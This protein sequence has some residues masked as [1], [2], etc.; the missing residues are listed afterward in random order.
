MIILSYKQY[1]KYIKQVMKAELYAF[2]CW[3]KNNKLYAFLMVVWP[4]LMA[5]FLLELGLMLGNLDVYKERMNVT[6]PILY[7]ILSS[8]ILVS[9][10][11]IVDQAVASVLMHRWIGTLPYVMTSLPGF[12]L[13]IIFGPLLPSILSSFIVI[14]AIMPAALLIEGVLGL[15]KI[16][17]ALAFIYLA[18]FPLLGFSIIIAGITLVLREETNIVSFITPFMMVLSGVYYPLAVLPLVLQ[19]LARVVPV[20]YVVEAVKILAV[21]HVPP[22]NKLFITAGILFGL[23]IVYNAVAIPGV[24]YVEERIRSRGIQ[25]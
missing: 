13:V 9:S 14:S 20:Y 1:I 25:D 21:Y 16:L 22:F 15:G 5:G 11:S 23:T 4:Y 12:R 19:Y 2:Y 3:M 7:I 8:G 24:K 6:N 18:L 17:M 10:L